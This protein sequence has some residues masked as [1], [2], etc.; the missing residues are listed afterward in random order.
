ME[1]PI[2]E[3]VLGNGE[4]QK[5]PVGIQEFSILRKGK[6]LYVDK[7][8]QI[9]NFI[10]SGSAWFLSRP[11]R[12]GKSLLVSTLQALFRGEKHLFEG[13]YIDKKWDWQ[14]YNVIR[15]DFTNLGTVT[16]DDLKQSLI[17]TMDNISE[18]NHIVTRSNVIAVKF[19]NLIEGL[20]KSNGKQVVVLIDE[21]DKPILDRLDAMKETEISNANKDILRNF[22]EVLKGQSLYLRFI[23][24]TGVTKFSGLSIFSGLNNLKDLTLRDEF[25]DICGYTQKELLV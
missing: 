3:T 7:T 23:F 10:S 25:S 16:P 5:L 19:S 6:Y 12:F 1:T 8:K 20:Y 14:T 18:S 15:I 22:Y 17:E 11:R 13:L 4:L 9:Y 24:I 21:Y 2:N